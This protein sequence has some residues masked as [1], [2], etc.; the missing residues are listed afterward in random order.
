MRHSSSG[1]CAGTSCCSSFKV[2]HCVCSSSGSG[3]P[4]ASLE[5]ACL[6]EEGRASG[7]AGVEAQ[8]HLSPPPLPAECAGRFQWSN[9][10]H[11][12]LPWLWD[13]GSI[14]PGQFPSAW[15]R[16]A[17]DA[18]LPAIR[19]VVCFSDGDAAV[20]SDAA[21]ETSEASVR[22]ASYCSMAALCQTRQQPSEM[23]CGQHAS[24]MQISCMRAIVLLIAIP[25]SVPVRWSAQS[26][27]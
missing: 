18:A 25:C 11:P 27:R 2:S 10:E 14:T 21:A 4:G 16:D 1:S 20:L 6:L 15:R 5:A 8:S 17:A 9:A 24:G 3:P 13:A 22:E 12:P 7:E 19:G 26:M 23:V